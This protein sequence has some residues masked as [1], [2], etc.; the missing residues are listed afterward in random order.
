MDRNRETDHA[1]EL[2]F[3]RL[4]ART[5]YWSI[6]R[7]TWEDRLSEGMLASLDVTTWLTDKPESAA[8][9]ETDKRT[10]SRRLDAGR[11]STLERMRQYRLRRKLAREAEADG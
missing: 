9:R 8:T 10:R 6:P 3:A 5:L 11:V 2:G 7:E 4:L 1:I